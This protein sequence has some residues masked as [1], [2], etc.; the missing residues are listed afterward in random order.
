MPPAVPVISACA[1]AMKAAAVSVW[2]R[3]NG[4]PACPGGFD[5]VGVAPTARHAEQAANAGL[6]QHGNNAIGLS[7]RQCPEYRIIFNNHDDSN[8]AGSV[9][10]RRRPAKPHNPCSKS[11]RRSAPNFY[12][13]PDEKG[14]VAAARKNLAADPKNPDLLMKLEAAQV[15]V[16]Q[17]RE[18]VATC[19]R[20]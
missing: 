4:R 5:Q 1:A 13:L 15:S 9:G 14:V 6:L 17:D 11:L 20:R 12:S 18:A 8:L 19:T 16:W 3:V 10:R 2:A 7:H